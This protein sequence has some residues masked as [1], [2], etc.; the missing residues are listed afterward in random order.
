MTNTTKL[1]YISMQTP[2]ADTELRRI[3]P[4]IA[5]DATETV[6]HASAQPYR[7]VQVR[8]N[9]VAEH[10]EATLHV[11]CALDWRRQLHELPLR[12]HR[13]WLHATQVLV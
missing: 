4:A 11:Q 12:G 13:R 1:N 10:G 8:Q 9:I 6:G 7:G 2:Q 3:H 5:E